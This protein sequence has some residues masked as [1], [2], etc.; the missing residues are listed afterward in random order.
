MEDA[1]EDKGMGASEAYTNH[2]RS[3]NP[4]LEAGPEDIDVARVERVYKYVE[5]RSIGEIY[6]HS[7]II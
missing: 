7:A 2:E 1:L 4:N 5:S 3:S 6:A